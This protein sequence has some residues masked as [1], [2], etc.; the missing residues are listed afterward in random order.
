MKLRFSA[1]GLVDGGV[2][3]AIYKNEKHEIEHVV[4]LVEWLRRQLLQLKDEAEN[5]HQSGEKYLAFNQIWI[6]G[7]RMPFAAV[8]ATKSSYTAFCVH[9]EVRDTFDWSLQSPDIDKVSVFLADKA[10]RVSDLDWQPT[11]N[12][13]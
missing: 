9:P 12:T 3:C 1:D 11:G 10:M 4:H 5:K 13:N 7:G 2:E 8:K 6:G